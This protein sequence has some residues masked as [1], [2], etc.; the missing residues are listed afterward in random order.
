M[1]N[2]LYLFP[3]LTTYCLNLLGNVTD[4]ISKNVESTT[5][6]IGFEDEY[7]CKETKDY[8][9]CRHCSNIDDSGK[10]IHPKYA[11]HIKTQMN[12]VRAVLIFLPFF[13]YFHG[14]NEYKIRVL[15]IIGIIK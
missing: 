4:S 7:F 5:Q 10:V 11:L 13:S 3:L 14:Q 8:R 6:S 1:S 2:I 12:V 9:I 15:N